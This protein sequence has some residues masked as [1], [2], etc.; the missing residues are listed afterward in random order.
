MMMVNTAEK[1]PCDLKDCMYRR[2]PL[3]GGGSEPWDRSMTSLCQDL[4]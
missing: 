2:I 3:V 1:V 4:R